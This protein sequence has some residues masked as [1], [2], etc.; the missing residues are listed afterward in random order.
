MRKGSDPNR[1]AR[2][3]LAAG[4]KG[5]AVR[6][7]VMEETRALRECALDARKMPGRNAAGSF[8]RPGDLPNR[9]EQLGYDTWDT[10]Q[11]TKALCVSPQA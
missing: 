10:I 5:S 8:F 7:F 1:F 2:A 4:A 3:W 11:H 6:G 9:G